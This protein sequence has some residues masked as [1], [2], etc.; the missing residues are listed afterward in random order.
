MIGNFAGLGVRGIRTAK[1]QNCFVK[2]LLMITIHS[3]WLI[4]KWSKP[5]SFDD[6]GLSFIDHLMMFPDHHSLIIC[7]FQ[8]IIRWSFDDSRLSFIYHLMIPDFHSSIIWWFHIIIHCF[9]DNSRLSFI[10]HLTTSSAKA[11]IARW[12]FQVLKSEYPD[13]YM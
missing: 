3:R 10:D 11:Q 7:C 12:I 5:W 2:I 13:R 4:I 1:I 6:C 9:C 8:I